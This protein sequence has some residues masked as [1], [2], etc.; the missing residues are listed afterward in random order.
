MLKAASLLLAATCVASMAYSQDHVVEGNPKSPVRVIAYEDL[1]C[2]IAL[3]YRKMMDD[4]CCRSTG[5]GCFRAPRFS[6]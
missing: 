5:Y 2:P 4:N 1:Q 6:A 3:L